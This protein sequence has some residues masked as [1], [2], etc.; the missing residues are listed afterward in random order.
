MKTLVKALDDLGLEVSESNQEFCDQVRKMTLQVDTIDLGPARG[1]Q[2]ATLWKDEAVMQAWERRNEFQVDDSIGYFMGEIDRIATDDYLP[3]TEDVLHVR[4][5]TTGLKE[6]QFAHQGFTF[7]VVDVGGQRSERRKWIHCF[8][9]VTAILFVVA[10]ID[11]ALM[12][13]EEED[14]NRMV[15]ALELFEKVVNNRWFKQVNTILFLNKK[16]LFE[17][18]IKR[19][20]LTHGFPDYTGDPHDYDECTKYLTQRFRGSA[21]TEGRT[22]YSYLTCATDTESV[23]VVWRAVHET[24]TSGAL[25]RANLTG[26]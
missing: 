15:E 11:Y 6:M 17:Q 24:L 20:P 26:L 8:Q 14:T 22:I 13:E 18:M 23:K 12:L 1:S 4:I 7:R 16:D 21:G 19:V 10:L 3:T 25:D 5:K 9:D 2:L